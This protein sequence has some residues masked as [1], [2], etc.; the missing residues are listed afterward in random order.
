MAY[1][2]SG[3]GTATPNQVGYWV[4]YQLNNG[5]DFGAQFAEAKPEGAVLDVSVD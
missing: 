1:N 5:Q 2:F 3:W 4:G